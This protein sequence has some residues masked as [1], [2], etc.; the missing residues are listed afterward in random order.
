MGQKGLKLR[1]IEERSG[2]EITDGYAADIL[3]GRSNNPSV[4]KIKALARALGVDA[5]VLFEIACGPFPNRIG[6]RTKDTSDTILF[7]SMMQ[8]V[9]ESPEMVQIVEQIVRLAPRERG[10]VL[11]Y[12]ESLSQN[13]RKSQRVRKQQRSKK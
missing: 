12:L 13:K 4:A 11:R 9:A 6:R 3:S 2:G 10:I 8:E 7:L 1:H 5:H